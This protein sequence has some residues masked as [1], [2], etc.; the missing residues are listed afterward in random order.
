MLLLAG[1]L[2]LA[3]VGSFMFIGEVESSES[4]SAESGENL[5]DTETPENGM[6]EPSDDADPSDATPPAT[7]EGDTIHGTDGND[8]LAGDDGDST[9]LGGD[10]SDAIDGG[11]GDDSLSGEG[12]EDWIWAGSDNDIAS[13]GDDD[14]TLHGESGDD[15][16]HGNDGDDEIWG[17]V[18]SDLSMGGAGN[19]YIQDGIGE[20]TLVGGAGDDGLLGG[21]DDDTLIGG[22]GEDELF[23]GEGND[24]LDGTERSADGTDMDGTDYLNGN[25]GNDT[26]LAGDGDIVTGGEG[27]DQIVLTASQNETVTLIDFSQDED[28][29]LIVFDVVP[30]EADITLTPDETDPDLMYL[31]VDGEIVATLH[32][33]AHMT[34]DDISFISSQQAALWESAAQQ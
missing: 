19:D 13:G 21:H 27:A 4:E 5:S 3:A 24:L 11:S 29:L 25:E 2:G 10:G 22:M 7:A 16:L 6:I 26:I 17:H 14:D 9:I 32:G 1:I 30:S 23:G 28:Q 33:A 20:D 18:G 8:T 12:G 34:A 31:D 15:T